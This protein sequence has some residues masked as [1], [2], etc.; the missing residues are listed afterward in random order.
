MPQLTKIAK[1][2]LP[3]LPYFDACLR[4]GKVIILHFHSCIVRLAFMLQ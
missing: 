2:Q 3:N 4:L 1:P